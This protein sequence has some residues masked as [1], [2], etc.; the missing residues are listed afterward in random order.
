MITRIS[1]LLFFISFSFFGW[2]LDK[3][4]IQELC[5]LDFNEIIS[6]LE[7]RKVQFEEA[8]NV[9]E[10][11]GLDYE[12]AEIKERLALIHY[13]LQDVDIGLKYSMEAVAY[14]EDQNDFQRVANI[15]TDLGF[16]I[17]EIQLER[18]IEYFRMALALSKEY[19][20]GLGLS[21]F[22]N[23]Y[24]TLMNK[25]GKLD[26][27]LYYHLKSLEICYQF[28]DSIGIPYSLNNAALAYS[29]LGQFE[30]A[31][32]MLDQSDAIRK[33]EHNDLSWADNL[34]Y[35]ADIYFEQTAYDSAVKYYEQA[36]VLSKKSKFVNLVTFSL[37][38][39]SL[40]YE[41]LGDDKNAL[42]YIKL[43]HQ[44]KDSVVSVETNAAIAALQE[45]FNASEKQK[46]IAEQSLEIEKQKQRELYIF[47]AI[48]GLVLGGTWL[49]VFQIRKRRTERLKMEH[50]KQ[51]EKAALEK[52]FVDEKVRISR[53]L[54]DN[55]GSQLTF[56]ISSVDNLSYL[57]EEEKKLS[58]LTRI[59]D[60]GRQ[61]M[62]E[63]RTTIWAMKKDGGT[64]GDLILKINDLKRSVQDII[65][66]EVKAD[67]NR[68]VQLN[69]LELLNLYRIVQEAVQNSIKY[70]EGQNVII[71]VRRKEDAI[72]FSIEDD[73]IGFDVDKM[74]EAGNGLTNM[75]RRCE[76]FGG[77]YTIESS[78]SGT[79]VSCSI[80]K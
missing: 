2:S 77:I 74:N 17:K 37:E 49:V 36:L 67:E 71:D 8:L 66:V 57:E 69:A 34:A 15:Y 27:A 45:E 39:L 60:F 13:Y 20:M 75:K 21:K 4:E 52:E 23:N 38:R 25:A 53:E 14:Y 11:L 76:E 41:N 26:S 68:Q 44:H 79:C 3:K 50:S 58:R 78:G 61:T 18:G 12:V 40:C 42:K 31:F 63:L 73:G 22:Y 62:K 55:I 43:L 1:L 70:G 54:H 72:T 59:S 7:G 10:D 48:L 28:N 46:K 30:K 51:L 5:E 47:F 56:M 16:A 9:A 32:E 19:D 35:R 6:N 29:Q 65:E 80:R 64:I 33:L 24:G